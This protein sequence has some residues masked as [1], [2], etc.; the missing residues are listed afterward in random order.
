MSLT[1]IEIRR[2]RP[3][4]KPIRLFDGGGLY[5][6]V[7]PTGGK[8]WRIKYRFSGKEKR[9]SLGVY[10]NVSL[11]V[12]RDRRDESRKL[13][14]DGIDPGENRE[15]V[16]S[17]RVER[18]AN[19]LEVVTREWFAKFSASWAKSHSD[20]IIRRFERDIFPWIGGP[21]DCRNNCPGTADPLPKNRKPWGIGNRAPRS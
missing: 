11:K 6:E 15:A 18:A 13:L 8:W 20:R 4:D 7:S 10:P 17:V 12:A 2:A 3:G 5:L 19:S 1:D 21:A 9:L 14:A 16:K